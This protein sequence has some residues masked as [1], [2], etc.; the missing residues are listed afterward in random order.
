MNPIEKQKLREISSLDA[1]SFFHFL[2]EEGCRLSLISSGQLDALQYQLVELLAGRFNRWTGGFSSSVPVETGQSIQQSVFYTIGYYLKGLPDVECALE[3]LKGNPLKELFL[4]GKKLIE[5]NLAEANELLRSIQKDRFSTDVL[6]YNDTLDEGLPIFFSSYDTDYGAHETPASVDYP[7]G[8]DRMNLTG[9]E[10]IS[11]YLRKLRLENEFCAHFPEEEI[12][13]LLR[14]YDRQYKELLFNIYELVLINAVGCL[15][16]DQTENGKNEKSGNEI[17][18]RISD[19]GRQ[20]LQRELSP[21]T[22][23]KIDRLVNEA[24][25]LLCRVLS[26]SDGQL[27]NYLA[28]SAANLKSRLKSALETDS[29]EHLFLSTEEEPAEPLIQ[30]SDKASLDHDSF[31]RL[32]DE[33]RECRLIADKILLLLREPLSLGDLIDLLEGECFFAEE[34]QDVFASLE[35]IRLALLV[36]KLPL[37]PADSSFLAEES[38][39]EW[40]I[41]LNSFLTQADPGRKSAI[42]SLAKQ[43][44]V[45]PEISRVKQST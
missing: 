30:F 16:I 2:V 5:S 13:C 1:I 24:I 19:L 43:L 11:E 38:G 12:L 4:L 23:G 9:I 10:Y 21:L 33:I 39:R 40:Q 18:L 27:I 42:L 36:K 3:A 17:R 34:Y 32:A 22:A 45:S 25:S 14:G 20:Y 31:R 6:A 28:A 29:L 8:N 7:L 15:L 44:E 35:D 37:D 26:L 41:G